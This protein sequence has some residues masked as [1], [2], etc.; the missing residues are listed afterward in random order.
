M[1]Q[2]VSVLLLGCVAAA[3][4]GDRA[5]DNTDSG[6][7]LP[8]SV[9]KDAAAD[10]GISFEHTPGATGQ[11]Y[12]PEIMGAGGAVFDYD[13]DGD[14]DVLLIQGRD[15]DSGSEATPLHR[16]FRNELD[17]AGK[18]RFTDVSAEAGIVTAHYGMGVAIGDVDGD[19]DPDVYITGFGNNYLFRNNGNGTFSDVT[20]ASGTNDPRWSTS[21]SFF[22]MDGDGD[23][24][25]YVANYVRFTLGNNILCTLRSGQRD[26]CT[27]DAYPAHRDSLFR[28]DGLGRFS[29]VSVSSGIA[30]K[31]GPGLGVLA[32]D[33]NGD[34]HNDLYVAN[35]KKANF[36]WLN[37]G[38][39]KFSETALMAGA[40]YNR[41]GT[42]EASMGVT[43]ADFDGD[44]DEDLF[45]THLSA[46]T[47]TLYLNNGTGQ[48]ED[49]TDRFGL[50]GESLPYTGFGSAFFDVNNDGLLDLFVANGAVLAESSQAGEPWPYRQK[51]QLFVN[52]GKRFSDAS[53]A[54]GP[55]MQVAAVGRGAAFG[56]VDN[57]GDVDVLVTNNSGV[58][59]LLLNEAGNS[60]PWLRVRL[61][62]SV[63]VRDPVG[64]RVAVIGAKSA[65]GAALWRR[66]HRDGSYLSASDV[67]VHFGLAGRDDVVAVGVEWPDGRR[68]RWPL[69]EINQ[70]IT[71]VAG[72]GQPWPRD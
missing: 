56:D 72:S 38:T 27:P 58:A 47:N 2:G 10:V 46:E 64:A 23:L 45:M 44:G 32:A 52:G 33:F 59:R 34:G 53:A 67:R 22:D 49:A 26:Y 8:A 42:P 20:A 17:A 19:A 54:A 28:N 41:A 68:E 62:G 71:L 7:S 5:T 4:G 43:A 55:A 18:L 1:R 12:F 37:N 60:Q 36:F 6:I 15:L 70:E 21:A 25:L 3:C 50:G 35:D 29:D 48:F 14:L 24:D 39:G 13:G 65:K 51:N 31:A 30:S 11:F 61:I 66:A 40:A 69:K 16:L 9:F 57:D 63:S